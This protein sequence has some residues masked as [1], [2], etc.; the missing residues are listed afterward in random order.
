MAGARSTGASFARTPVPA[1]RRTG[2]PTLIAVA[3]DRKTSSATEDDALAIQRLTA[4]W[5]VQVEPVPWDAPADWGRYAAVLIR[6]T[7]DYHLRPSA[8]L[9]WAELV[10]RSGAVLWNPASVVRWNADKRYLADL[11]RAGVPVIPTERIP[12]GTTVQLGQL[13]ERLGWEQ[14]IV[15]PAVSAGSYRTVRLGPDDLGD[16]APLIRAILEET[17]ALVQPFLPEVCSEGEWSFIYFADGNGAL[18]FSHAVLKRPAPADFR[19]QSDYG[20]TAEAVAPP[21]SLLRQA[22]AAVATIARL[23]PGPLL[24]AR[25]D[26]VVSAGTHGPAGTLLLM[27][28]ELIEPAL[29][30]ATDAGAADRFADAVARRLALA[31]A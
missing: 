14:A 21:P 6:S 3:T 16:S 4:R 15:K 18:A 22:D 13:L 31:P 10:E 12:R 26:G 11:A 7:W 28:A 19:V 2:E 9:A 24:Y 5:R 1:D 27:E 29:F 17:D 25:I 23:A 20:G 8:F 30:F